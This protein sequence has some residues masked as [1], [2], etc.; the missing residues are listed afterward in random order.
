MKM[1]EFFDAFEMDRPKW[2]W[3]LDGELFSLPLRSLA[4][5]SGFVSSIES[6]ASFEYEKKN[7]ALS[8]ASNYP[9]HPTES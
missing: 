4:P 2:W 9:V 8:E 7:W 1:S 5:I 6:Q 3:L